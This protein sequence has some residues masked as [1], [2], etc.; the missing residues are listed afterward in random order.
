MVVRRP[1][2]ETL[3][4]V[5]VAA[6][7]AQSQHQ[8]HQQQQQRQQHRGISTGG[9]SSTLRRSTRARTSYDRAERANDEGCA[10]YEL[11]AVPDYKDVLC[12]EMS[13]ALLSRLA[14]VKA[15]DRPAARAAGC[16]GR[17]RAVR[18]QVP[19]LR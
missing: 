12:D 14:R 9:M 17:G 15:L 10:L 8:H 13:H 2:H 7:E 5:Y 11:M 19:L 6:A 16:G 1:G 18:D 4:L 3:L